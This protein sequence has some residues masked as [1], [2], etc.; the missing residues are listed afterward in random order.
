MKKIKLP[1]HNTFSL[2]FIPED[3][4][5]KEKVRMPDGNMAVN[6]GTLEIN[7]NHPD[8][9]QARENGSQVIWATINVELKMQD[10]ITKYLFGIGIGFNERLDFF[11][12]EIM[13]S[14]NISFS[15]KKK[16]V[17]KLIKS[18]KL[19]SNKKYSELDNNLVKV[20]TY[21]NAFAHGKLSIDNMDGCMLEFYSGRKQVFSLNDKFWNNLVSQYLIV[22]TLLGEASKKL[23]RINMDK[24]NEDKKD[25]V[26]K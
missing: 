17:L 20:M 21:R 8:L 12:N 25:Y 24:Y 10:I 22:N 4:L 9:L 15:F 6:I 7:P 19:I 3:I 1:T 5:K 2:S 18:K 13:S 16:L 11:N 14:N 23:S 26:L